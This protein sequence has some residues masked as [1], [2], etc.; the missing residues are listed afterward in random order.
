MFSPGRTE[1]T[2]IPP[3]MVA[4]PKSQST[5]ERRAGKIRRVEPGAPGRGAGKAGGSGRSGGSSGIAAG[6]AGGGDSSSIGWGM[7][8]VRLDARRRR[9]VTERIRNGGGLRGV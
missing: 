2:A 5:A 4:K 9:N 7:R 3:R 8:V 1:Q 6:A